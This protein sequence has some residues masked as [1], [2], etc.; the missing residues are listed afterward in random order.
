MGVL[1]AFFFFFF[2]CYTSELSPGIDPIE[3]PKLQGGMVYDA[4]V[5]KMG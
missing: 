5:G 2:K 1:G 3:R 4:K